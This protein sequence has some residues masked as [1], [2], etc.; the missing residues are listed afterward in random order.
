M[1]DLTYQMT[2]NPVK[3]GRGGAFTGPHIAKV[4]PP[5][6]V[7]NTGSSDTGLWDQGDLRDLMPHI[8]RGGATLSRCLHPQQSVPP[9]G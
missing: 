4:D 9:R 2:R 5:G 1:G 3:R 8:L 6:T 7:G